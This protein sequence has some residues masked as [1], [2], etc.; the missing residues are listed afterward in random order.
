MEF[1]SSNDGPMPSQPKEIM[2]RPPNDFEP[3]VI[4]TV[5]LFNRLCSRNRNGVSVP[6]PQPSP[7]GATA[8]DGGDQAAGDG[9]GCSAVTAAGSTRS[10]IA[11]GRESAKPGCVITRT[12][13]RATAERVRRSM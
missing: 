9:V 11:A 7:T 12:P 4:G 2:T 5:H 6:Q 3:M 13:A 1:S 8:S 10:A